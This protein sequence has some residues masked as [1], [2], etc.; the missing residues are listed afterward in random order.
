MDTLRIFASGLWDL[1]KRWPVR[2]QA[3]IVAAIA[4]GTAFGLSW[5]GTQVG[6]VSAFTAA[7]LAFVTE[8]AVTPVGTP[9]LVLGTPVINPDKPGGD[10]PPPDLIVAVR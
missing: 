10:T 5:D 6:A 4:L 9:S 1:I 2:A 7:L 8:Q 3:V